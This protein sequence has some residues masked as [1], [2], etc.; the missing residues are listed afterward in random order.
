MLR[1]AIVPL[2]KQ[3]SESLVTKISALLVIPESGLVLEDI[4]MTPTRVETRHM[5]P[6]TSK[7]WDTSWC[8]EKE[9]DKNEQTDRAM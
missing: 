4:M 6:H 9:T 3:E 2:L 8:S 1:V 7:P 5:V